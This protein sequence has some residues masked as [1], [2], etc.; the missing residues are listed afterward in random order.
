MNASPESRLAGTEEITP[1]VS[2]D[3]RTRIPSGIPR[4]LGSQTSL[5]ARSVI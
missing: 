2:S 5:A 3:F 4:S 1:T